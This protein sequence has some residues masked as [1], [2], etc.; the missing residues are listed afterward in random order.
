MTLLIFLAVLFVL[1]LVHEWGH[2]ITAK[3]TGMQVDEF[4]IGFPPKLFGKKI[5]ETEYTLNALPI[6]GFVRIVGENAEDIAA[7]EASDPNP[8]SFVH[9]SKWAQALVLIAG[10]T[11]NVLFAWLLY[12][13][14]FMIGAPT[15]VDEAV[16]SPD[17][18]LTITSVVPDSPAMRAGVPT[19]A[20]IL[21]VQRDGQQ[22]QSLTPSAFS[23]F[24]GANNQAVTLTYQQG[25][26][27]A[28]TTL[29][30]LP[31][32]LPDE[33]ERALIGVSVGFIENQSLG[34]L[35]AL[36]EATKTSGQNLI[37]VTVGLYTL[38][39]DAVVGQADLSSVTGPVGIS[40]MVGD[41]AAVGFTSLLLFTAIISLNLAIIN[42]LPI[43]ALDGGRLLMVGIEAITRR[44]INPAWVL[45]LNGLGMIILLGLMVVVTVNDVI[46][47]FF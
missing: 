12:V 19:G 21:S 24:V 20:E 46:R 43:P 23:A 34:L 32:V 25:E 5:G 28:V 31:G 17:T 30:P 42:L 41:A 11:M 36:I 18:P 29:R 33:P 44:P 40:F 27:S 38:L 37:L 22:L 47:Y 6:G 9:K 14:V 3:K 10:V 8:H 13:V 1:I 2:Y 4:G 15:V 45:R 39:S 26:V 35:P 16:A 7:G